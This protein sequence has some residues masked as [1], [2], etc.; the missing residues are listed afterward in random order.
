MIENLIKSIYKYYTLHYD[1]R[2]MPMRT[3]AMQPNAVT[4]LHQL[5]MPSCQ[6][7]K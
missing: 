4:Q 2:R 5:I 3:I 6:Q 7:L 1:A